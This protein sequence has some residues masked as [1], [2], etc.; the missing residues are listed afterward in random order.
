MKLVFSV[1]NT[2]IIILLSSCTMEN[3]NE[4][5]DSIIDDNK[6]KQPDTI[7]LIPTIQKDSSISHL[8][9]LAFP[10]GPKISFEYF[11]KNNFQINLY[12]D[13]LLN[14]EINEFYKLYDL[15]KYNSLQY[16]SIEYGLESINCRNNKPFDSMLH[17]SKYMFKLPD[18][19]IFDCYYVYEDEN[20]N[21]FLSNEFRKFCLDYKECGHLILFN[22][23]N[24]T[25]KVLPVYFYY[26]SD[27]SNKF[28]ES[29]INKDGTIK[30]IDSWQYDIINEKGESDYT[31]DILS[32][33][34]IKIDKEG[35]IKIDNLN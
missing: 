31:T 23:S 11:E 22:K 2:F 7:T 12:K 4:N 20:N 30:V 34:L 3:T 28:R 17:F 16:I 33:Y 24:S 21:K 18:I 19:S 15:P 27:G 6:M 5:V 35:N 26:Y 1:S 32:T 13:I 25:A 9:S 29:F 10:F 14:K 8:D